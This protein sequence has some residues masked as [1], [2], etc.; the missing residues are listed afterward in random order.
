[1]CR[2]EGTRGPL[3]GE[4][5]G[6]PGAERVPARGCCED[7]LSG[8]LRSVA[9]Q[10]WRRHAPNS[11]LTGFLCLLWREWTTKESVAEGGDQGEMLVVA[12]WV[13]RSG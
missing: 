3:R 2:A 6:A 5:G 12:V 8:T 4:V 7:L 10:D 13:V 1:M 9:L 11:V